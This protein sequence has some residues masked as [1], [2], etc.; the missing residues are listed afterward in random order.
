MQC[1]VVFCIAQNNTLMKVISGN[2]NISV[3]ERSAPSGKQHQL[4]KKLTQKETKKNYR[5]AAVGR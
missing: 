2:E 5:S 3:I 1:I 4:F